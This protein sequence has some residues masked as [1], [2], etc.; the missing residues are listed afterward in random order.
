MQFKFNL[1]NCLT[2]VYASLLVTGESVEEQRKK[3]QTININQPSTN[4]IVQSSKVSLMLFSSKLSV[5][6]LLRGWIDD[7][8]SIKQSGSLVFFSHIDT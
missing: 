5:C 2:N 6:R 1:S 4:V 3:M 7:F 8:W